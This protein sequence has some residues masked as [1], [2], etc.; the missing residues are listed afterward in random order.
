MPG[1]GKKYRAVKSKIDSGNISI[2]LI[3]ENF[4]RKMREEKRYS[5]ID[6]L[7]GQAEALNADIRIINS[8]DASK[9]LDGL[10]GIACL[11]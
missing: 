7:M 2:L 1:H 3:S 6:I 8:E 4:I 11:L 10:S 5:E 9:K